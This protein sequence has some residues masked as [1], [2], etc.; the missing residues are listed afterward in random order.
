MKAG[1]LSNNWKTRSRSIPKCNGVFYQGF[2]R[3]LE[4]CFAEVVR[5]TVGEVFE[6]EGTNQGQLQFV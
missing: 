5:D 1:D 6:G 2:L 3:I 4:E